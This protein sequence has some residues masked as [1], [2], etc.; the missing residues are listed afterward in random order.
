MRLPCKKNLSR[1]RYSRLI[2]KASVEDDIQDLPLVQRQVR[3]FFNTQGA[4][5]MIMSSIYRIYINRKRSE[6]EALFVKHLLYNSV[7]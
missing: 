6:H 4:N 5:T 2:K 3:R 1:R 7:P